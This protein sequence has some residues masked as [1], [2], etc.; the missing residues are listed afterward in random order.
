MVND[1]YNSHRVEGL[2]Y[3]KVVKLLGPPQSIEFGKVAYLVTLK[4]GKGI[5][6]EYAKN[7]V[8]NF[9]KDTVATSAEI[10]EEKK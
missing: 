9:D 4:Y 5:Y 3:S 10:Q 8:I 7:F 1:L 6:P 2:R